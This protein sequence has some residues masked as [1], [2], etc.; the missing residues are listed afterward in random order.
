[1][2]QKLFE[3]W[4]SFHEDDEPESRSDISAYKFT[5][6][7]IIAKRH[8]RM[9]MDILSDIRAIEGVTTL[10]INAQRTSDTLDFS[11]V[12]VKID[13][14]PLEVYDL[15]TMIRL[16]KQEI[17]RTKGVQNFRITSKPESL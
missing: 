16:I 2:M 6:I 8:S 3:A 12:T 11:N 15:N 4:R 14:T 13:T 1:M 7:L 9:K 17:R 10:S 5:G